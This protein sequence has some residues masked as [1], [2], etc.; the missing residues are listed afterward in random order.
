M[1]AMRG[2]LWGYCFKVAFFKFPDN[3]VEVFALLLAT[4]GD[5]H[6]PAESVPDDGISHPG[7]PHFFKDA[8]KFRVSLGEFVD[9]FA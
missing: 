5:G 6:L 4:P 8:D 2:G 7:E 3:L 9:A 1:T